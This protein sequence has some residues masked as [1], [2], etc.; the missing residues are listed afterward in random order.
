MKW[1]Y[2]M[3]IS[4]QTVPLSLINLEDRSFVVTAGRSTQDLKSSIERIGLVNHPRLFF[5]QTKGCYQVVCGYRRIAALQSLGR[6]EVP[7][8][9]FAPETE[10]K[11]LLLYSICDNLPHRTFNP[12]EAADAVTKLLEY[13]PPKD[14]IETYLPLLGLPS[15]AG[16]LEN[17]LSIAKLEDE[18]KEGII[19]GTLTEKNAIRLS[20][21]DPGER[22]TIFGLFCRVHL[23]ASKQAELIENLADIARRDEQSVEEIL[24]HRETA[25][26]LEQDK[27]PLSQKGE[28][29]R[30]WIRKKR[31][32][33]LNRLEEKFLSLN[34]Q[35]ALPGNIKLNPPPFFEGQTYNITLRFENTESLDKA[36]DSL[37]LLA[38]N[39]LLIDFLE[40]QP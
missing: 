30:Q 33:R 27:L 13:F 31:F 17:S 10:G 6:G 7:V 22:L 25:K 8:K 26:I 19:K 21:M 18:I 23:S 3:N 4:S 16:T 9:V 2:V 5:S 11:K 39:P 1:G 35:L 20:E 15:F 36:A 37:K 29:I 24:A 28:R 38:K 40:K 12:V 32:P 34:K 14:I